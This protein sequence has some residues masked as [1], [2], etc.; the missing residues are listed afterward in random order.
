MIYLPNP[1]CPIPFNTIILRPNH[2]LALFT[3][4]GFCSILHYLQSY[5]IV[6][7]Y[8]EQLPSTIKILCAFIK[9]RS[10][11]KHKT[12]VKNVVMIIQI[13]SR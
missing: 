4:A 11:L 7:I 6:K 2:L 5:C 9:G 10:M 3:L 8:N 1:G 12:T 13:D